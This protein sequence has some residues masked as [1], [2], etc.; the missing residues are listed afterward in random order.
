[1]SGKESKHVKSFKQNKMKQGETVVS[2]LDG[3]IGEMLGKGDKKQHNG[4]LIVSDQRVVF[5]RKG[6]LGE[7]FETIP[8]AKITSVESSS[9]VGYKMLT[10]HTSHD[11]LKFKSFASAE[12]FKIT[13]TDIEEGRDK[14]I[15]ETQTASLDP[16]SQLKSLAELKEAGILSG[17]EFEE[18]K[19][20]L[21]AKI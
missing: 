10:L 18:K 21:L 13:F 16:V 7:V 15:A 5:Y 6:L 14:N 4:S 11:D 1:M 9:F 17:E 3:Y 2:F 19:A 12:L 20:S 8:L